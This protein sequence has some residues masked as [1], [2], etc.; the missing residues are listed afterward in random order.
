M[1][2]RHE[3]VVPAEYYEFKL[4]LFEGK[5]GNYRV[6][7]HWHQPIEIFLVLE[8][9]I[10]FYINEQLYR[11][12]NGDFMIVNSN[13]I[14]SINCPNRNQTVVLQIPL[15][16]FEGYLDYSPSFHFKKQE[17][18][19]NEQLS[20]L[21][22]EMYLLNDKKPYG[23]RLK[24]K[25]LFLE[26]LYLLITTFKEEDNEETIRQKKQL[27]RLSG[28]ISYLKEHYQ[29]DL[30]LEKVAS[31]CGFTPTYLSRMFRKY[32]DVNYLTYLQNLRIEYAVREL[33][34][35]DHPISKIAIHHGFSDSRAFT[36]AFRKRYQCLPSEYR[37]S[38]KK[39]TE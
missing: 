27:H 13:E 28:V 10:D 34:N 31:D 9:Q 8:G 12:Q 29:E 1:Q 21:I 3:L 35:T 26:V 39:C 11:I 7:K 37:K 4:F 15:E 33:L 25:S 38:A 2:F 16:A 30:S 24:V 5:D 14:H 20:L 23:Y 18:K 19:Q 17:D 36:K 6:S 32:A 22:H